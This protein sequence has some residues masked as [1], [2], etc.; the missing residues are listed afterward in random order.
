MPKLRDAGRRPK[1]RRPPP[2]AAM[3]ATGLAAPLVLA[4]EAAGAP[5]AVSLILCGVALAASWILMRLRRREA[6]RTE[7]LVARLARFAR[8]DAPD[9]PREPLERVVEGVERL[10]RRL[11]EARGGPRGER[12]VLPDRLEAI[13]RARGEIVRARR[14]NRALATALVALDPEALDEAG[15]DVSLRM[16]GDMLTQGLR[17]YDLV[18]RW[19]ADTFVALLPEAEI[20]N[21]AGAVERLRAA[22]AAAFADAPDAPRIL[23]GVAVLQPE[24]A[25]LA[26]MAER[27]EAALA[28]ARSGLGA[29]VGV[30]PGFRQRPARLTLVQAPRAS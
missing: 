20:E 2:G 28:R 29:E 1:L 14:N 5:Q 23:A 6:A 22:C 7:A 9:A 17:A 10:E 21:A 24:D 13:R 27:A 8:S 4:L 18:G 25:S 30:A 15:R 16:L 26:D 19:K 11:E 3:A 12:G